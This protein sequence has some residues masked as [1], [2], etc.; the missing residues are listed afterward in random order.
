MQVRIPFSL[1]AVAVS[2][3]LGYAAC[4]DSVTDPNRLVEVDGPAVSV[5][6]GTA[7]AVV[8]RR[9]SDVTSIGIQLTDGA[10]TNLPTTMP[11]TE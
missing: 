11:A 5:G 4:S 6:N 9:G 3:A 1:T 10:L 7:R 8:F 2:L